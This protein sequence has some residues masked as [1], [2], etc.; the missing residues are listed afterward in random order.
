[1]PSTNSAVK[2]ELC[3]LSGY[4]DNRAV[5]Y[6]VSN[7]NFCWILQNFPICFVMPG[8]KLGGAGA[9]GGLEC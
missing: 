3:L 9:V 8:C 5:V 1:M 2:A 6:R 7:G 4:F